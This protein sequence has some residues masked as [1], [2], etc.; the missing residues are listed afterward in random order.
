MFQEHWHPLL[1][2]W[3]PGDWHW[4]PCPGQINSNPSLPWLLPE[5]TFYNTNPPLVSLVLTTCL[6]S[7]RIKSQLLSLMCI[8]FVISLFSQLHMFCSGNTGCSSSA[9]IPSHFF[10]PH[11]W[12]PHE[13]MEKPGR[14]LRTRWQEWG[15][16]ILCLSTQNAVLPVWAW[17]WL[18]PQGT[19][20]CVLYPHGRLA[21]GA[22]A[23]L[24]HQPDLLSLTPLPLSLEMMNGSRGVRCSSLHALPQN[25][26]GEGPFQTMW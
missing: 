8:F 23:F 3:L 22:A 25:P 2:G 26:P 5:L 1:G 18:D 19:E 21:L 7:S 13:G 9:D 6:C 12:W 14:A 15:V 20:C 4:S 16:C 10:T 24:L 17:V 11:L